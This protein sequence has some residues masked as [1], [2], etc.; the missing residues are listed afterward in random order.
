MYQ[1]YLWEGVYKQ[2]VVE[3]KLWTYCCVYGKKR[4]KALVTGIKLKWHKRLTSTQWA[5]INTQWRT[6][7]TH[8]FKENI[9][10]FS[11]RYF[12]FCELTE[13]SRLWQSKIHKK[14]RLHSIFSSIYAMAIIFMLWLFLTARGFTLDYLITGRFTFW[15]FLK[16]NSSNLV[17]F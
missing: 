9:L 4:V 6:Y 13:K 7:G 1:D 15:I 14:H 11:F 16:P 3:H 17:K 8:K 5:Y 10:L 12:I 2:I